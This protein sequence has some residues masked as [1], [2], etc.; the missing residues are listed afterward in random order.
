MAEF[1]SCS[2]LSIKQVLVDEWDCGIKYDLRIMLVSEIRKDLKHFLEVS[3]SW[4]RQ[5]RGHDTYLKADINMAKLAY[6]S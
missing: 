2:V 3:L 6:P 1:T 4:K 5:V